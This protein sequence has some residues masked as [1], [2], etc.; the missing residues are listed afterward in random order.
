MIDA[1]YTSPEDILLLVEPVVMTPLRL[2]WAAVQQEVLAALAEEEADPKLSRLPPGLRPNRR[3][4]AI[5]HDWAVEL[6]GI[7]ILDP[8]CGSGNFLYMS[9]K[10]L[11]DLWLEARLFANNHTL[12]LG[13]DPMPNPTQLFGIEIDFYAHEIASIVVWIGFLQWKREHGIVDESSPLLQELTNIEIG[14]AIMR[15]DAEGRTYKPEWPAANYVVSNP[16]FLG[17]KKMK[18][19]LNTPERPNYVEA[20]RSLYTGNVPGGSDLVCYWFERARAL[21]ES[22]KAQRAG[23]IAT[24]SIRQGA[25]RKVLQRIEQSGS[26]FMAWSDR[27]WLLHG[28]AVRVSMVAFDNGTEETR[29]LDGT[30]VSGIHADLSG[31]DNFVSVLPLAENEGLCFLGDDERWSIRHLVNYRAENACC[32]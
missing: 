28:A 8:A 16:P 3:P 29:T 31:E 24:N 9:L 6:S 11:L 13:L 5:L 1:H 21:I 2:R 27:P 4:L 18:R 26:I 23:L 14:D 32:A 10:S 15:Y 25:N 12:A 20:L 19:E 7:R 17:D 22:S 30:A